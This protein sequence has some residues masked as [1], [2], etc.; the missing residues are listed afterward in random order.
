M[1]RDAGTRAGS[2][3]AW[4]RRAA[5]TLALVLLVGAAAGC[6]DD[7]EGRRLAEPSPDQTTTTAA[8]QSSDSGAAAG[9]SGTPAQVALSSTAF[10]DGETIPVNFTCRG[11]DRSP[12]LRW[13]GIPDGT[14]EIALVVRDVSIGG[15]VHW[16]IAGLDPA[17]GG[18]AEGTPPGG[19]V[20]AN[21]ALGRPGYS[22]PC[23]PSGTHNYEIRLY[24]LAE[25]SG[26][27]AGMPA[28]DA[29]QAVESRA[30]YSTSV[31]S[32]SFA[33]NNP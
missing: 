29:A 30:S 16:V 13:T 9:T 26:V 18:I 3:R 22:G 11:D 2:T 15:F 4:G 24:A 6:G 27:T 31:L 14:V 21:N 10:A 28:E 25:P 5:L 1:W 7:D 23:P 19:A 12:P 33:A 20:Q 17:L 8:G 32:G